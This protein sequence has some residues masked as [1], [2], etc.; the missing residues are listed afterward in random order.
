LR[1]A[2]EL[3]LTGCVN[4]DGLTRNLDAD[5]QRELDALFDALR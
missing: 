3:G 2:P 5:E 4:H 1:H